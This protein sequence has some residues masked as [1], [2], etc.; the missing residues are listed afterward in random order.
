MVRQGILNQRNAKTYRRRSVLYSALSAKSDFELTEGI[1]N[2]MVGDR[3][4]LLTDG[5]Y[6]LIQKGAIRDISLQA[7][8]VDKLLVIVQ[9][10]L[11]LI[12]KKDDATVVAID[13]LSA[14][15]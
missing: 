12:G 6:R 15:V 10:E 8:S 5:A 14:T 4:L 9:E 13:I 7:K 2:V 11:R 1:F 3:I